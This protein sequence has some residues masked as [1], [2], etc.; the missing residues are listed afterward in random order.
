MAILEKIHEENANN[1]T[2]MPS[3]AKYFNTDESGVQPL[4]RRNAASSVNRY[5]SEAAE[6][7]A[8]KTEENYVRKAQD[9]YGYTEDE[10]LRRDIAAGNPD[11]LPSGATLKMLHGNKAAPAKPF[12]NVSS[13]SYRIN[14]R[15]KLLFAVYAVV[16]L[17]LILVIVLNALAIERQKAV[18]AAIENE[19][20]LMSAA[21]ESLSEQSQS[22]T[23]SEYIKSQAESFGMKP[24]K[25][26]QLN[27][28]A[29][30]LA[31]KEDVKP[32]T[33]WFDW[34]CDL[35]S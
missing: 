7:Y 11:I 24:V 28:K 9:N 30:V 19:I 1:Q 34:I 6:S 12:D 29:P 14:A 27:I 35:M 3:R 23:D 31:N 10:E 33:N 13:V 25:T 26:V 18:N 4:F 20:S 22:L 2:S 32:Q 15:G 8:V 21:V 17:G 5:A 16:V